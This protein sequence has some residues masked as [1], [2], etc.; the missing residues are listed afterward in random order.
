M[1]HPA[2]LLQINTGLFGADSQ[3]TRL[4]DQFATRYLEARPELRRVV[5]DFSVNPVPHLDSARAKALFTPEAE[6]SPEQ[7]SVVAESDALIDELRSAQVVVIGLPM[8]N[9]QVPSTLKSYF[10][11]IARAGVSFQYTPN[12]PKGLL[13][14]RKVYVLAARG[15]QYSGTPKDTQTPYVEQFLSFIGLSDIEWIYAEGLKVSPEAAER[16]L[17]AAF[18]E[19]DESVQVERAV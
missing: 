11:H 8:Y 10:D 12:G 3:S 19:I 15:G 18:R 17:G 7:R 14:N 16:S 2:T 9:F 6:R 13:A 4:A 5:R 1:S